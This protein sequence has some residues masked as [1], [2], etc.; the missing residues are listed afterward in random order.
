VTRTHNQKTYIR[1]MLSLALLN[2]WIAA[3][4]SA[5]NSETQLETE[6]FEQ[7]R[8]SSAQLRIAPT[9]GVLSTNL[10]ELTPIGGVLAVSFSTSPF[11]ELG[12]E[13]GYLKASLNDSLGIGEDSKMSANLTMIPI[14]L[15]TLYRFSRGPVRPYIGVAVGVSINSVSVA[16]NRSNQYGSGSSNYSTGRSTGYSTSRY[17][18]DDEPSYSASN[19]SSDEDEDS[20][21]A[22]ATE[23]ELVLQARP[24]IEFGLSSNVAIYAEPRVGVVGSK[25]AFL[26]QVGLTVGL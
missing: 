25:L 21:S 22:S 24:G 11:L 6:M 8:Y 1:L 10:G 4:A 3:T 17:G 18:Y 13:T 14:L 23:V 5:S 9:L 19:R 12:L 2:S 15:T 16:I 7:T 20:A 26:P